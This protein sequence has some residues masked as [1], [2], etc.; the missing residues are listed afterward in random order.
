MLLLSTKADYS[1]RTSFSHD[2][3]RNRSNRASNG[4]YFVPNLA[5]DV[6]MGLTIS[7]LWAH[8]KAELGQPIVDYI[9]FL[10]QKPALL[11]LE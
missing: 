11:Y 2:L 6:C 8:S 10:E 4:S 9:D 3:Q 5:L 1:L 7:F